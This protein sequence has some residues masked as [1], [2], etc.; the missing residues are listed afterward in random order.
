MGNQTRAIKPPDAPSAGPTGRYRYS[1]IMY[2]PDPGY[3]TDFDEYMLIY[4]AGH[5]NTRVV[6]TT[7]TI[8]RKTAVGFVCGASGA[9]RGFPKDCTP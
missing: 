5:A 8:Q 2:P 1:N 3:S 4:L 9:N 7:W 6:T